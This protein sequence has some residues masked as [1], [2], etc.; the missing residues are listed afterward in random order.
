LLKLR[1]W[2]SLNIFLFNWRILFVP[3]HHAVDKLDCTHFVTTPRLFQ[4]FGGG[5]TRST[6]SAESQQRQRFQRRLLGNSI[7]QL[8]VSG[9]RISRQWFAFKHE[10]QVRL[11]PEELIFL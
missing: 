7:P 4:L 5:P 1:F 9:W 8:E 10:F 11:Q 3:I 2:D 6:H